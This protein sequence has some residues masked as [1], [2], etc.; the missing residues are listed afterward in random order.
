MLMGKQKINTGRITMM[1]RKSSR[2][3]INTCRQHSV[4][5]KS[6]QLEGLEER[7]MFSTVPVS[8]G[9]PV[10]SSNPSARAKLYLDFNGAAATTW[11]GFNVPA[12]PAYD[13][14]GDPTT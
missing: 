12:T 5:G 10:L 1:T 7:R 6:M 9:V 4:C 11:A 2:Q 13:T 8:T 3:K 14:D